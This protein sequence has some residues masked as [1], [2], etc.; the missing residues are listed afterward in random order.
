MV[1]GDW[2]H[3]ALSRLSGMFLVAL[4]SEGLSASRAGQAGEHPLPHCVQDR[5]GASE[6]LSSQVSAGPEQ[7]FACVLL[8]CWAGGLIVDYLIVFIETKKLV[9]G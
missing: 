2:L 6:S 8:S 7:A 4:T 3:R 5:V 9:Q 1:E